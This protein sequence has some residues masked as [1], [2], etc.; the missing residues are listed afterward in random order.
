MP[1]PL[2][3]DWDIST[4]T[5]FDRFNINTGSHYNNKIVERAN[6]VLTID[7]L[8]TAEELVK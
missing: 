6:K 3:D 4:A 2:F 1:Q 8:L 7:F 5:Y